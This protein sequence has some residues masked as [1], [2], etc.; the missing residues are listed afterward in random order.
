M[1]EHSPV[2]VSL[3]QLLPQ[4]EAEGYAVLDATTVAQW[5]Q[6]PLAELTAL[7]PDW[8]GMPEDAYLKDGGH[9]RLRR[10]S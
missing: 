10:H 7:V 3:S 8:E 5:A 4:L 1:L 9:Y 2:T 6:H